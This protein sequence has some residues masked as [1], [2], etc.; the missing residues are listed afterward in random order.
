MRFANLA[1]VSVIAGLGTLMQSAALAQDLSQT[2]AYG[3]FTIARAGESHAID[4]Q[5][6]GSVDAST[7]GNNCVGRIANAPDVQLDFTN[8]GGPLVFSVESDVD[9]SL[10]IN[11]AT[12]DWVCDDDSGNDF[13]AR[14]EIPNATSGIY[15]IWVGVY[16]EA[17]NFAEA[18][19]NIT[20]G[21]ASAPVNVASVPTGVDRIERGNLEV[22]DGRRPE[23]QYQDAYTFAG[24]AGEEV[25]FD[26]RSDDFDTYLIVRSPSGVETTNDDYNGDTRRSVV[27]RTLSESGQYQVVASSFFEDDAGPYTL[28]ISRPMATAPEL[29]IQENG[30]LAQGD[31]TRQSGA[32]ADSYT[33]DG[34]PGRRAVIDL[35]S[36]DFDTYLVLTSPSGAVIENDDFD[37]LSHSRI[38]S[39]LGESGTYTVDVTSYSADETGAYRLTI[40]RSQAIT[41]VQQANRDPIELAFGQTANGSL[42]ANDLETEPGKY[43]D[44]YY[45]VGQAGQNV[46]VELNSTNFDTYLIVRS[47]SGQQYDND[48]FESSL[49]RSRIDLALNESGRYQVIATSYGTGMTGAYQLSASVQASAAVTTIA[50]VIGSGEG[51]VYGIFA[52]ISDYSLLRQTE[53]GWGDLSYTADDARVAHDALIQ[54][55]GMNPNNAYMFTD[56]EATRGN[57]EAAFRDLA[58][59]MGPRDTFVFFYSG[60]GGQD[61]RAG[62]FNAADADGY[63]ETLALADQTI[64]DDEVNELFGMLNAGASLIILDSC[65]SGGFAKDV[66]SAPG[67]MGLFSSDEDVPSLV[68]GK[69]QAGGYLSFFFGEAVRD[70]QA[71]ED[72]DNAINAMELSQYIHIRYAEESMTKGPSRFDT[73]HFGYQHLVVDRGGV[74]H[75]AVLFELN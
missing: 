25:V 67:R 11:N 22:G 3:D 56:R 27:T 39:E 45:F 7:L 70:G 20:Q 68:A 59:R 48:D 62:G 41:T 60:H 63:D 13:N 33:F 5:A 44:N 37:S 65:F 32:F 75:D 15:D 18:T 73:P 36:T 10:V 54:H 23:G 34:S 19:L 12:G 17:E 31:A 9:T 4:L 47:P 35:N 46:R 69:F 49:S 51:T 52:G 58:G 42:A 72:G 64:T 50:N 28:S 30:T 61:E 8:S 55:A 57:I 66:V 38:D 2:A 6:G 71:D 53:A 40:D 24:T 14:V 43:S 21:A 74:A 29:R 16:S 1:A 26:M